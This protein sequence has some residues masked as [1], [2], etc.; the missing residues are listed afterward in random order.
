MSERFDVVHAAVA[1]A[2]QHALLSTRTISASNTWLLPSNSCSALA[3]AHAQHAAD[4]VGGVL[5]EGD[6]RPIGQRLQMVNAGMRMGSLILTK[7]RRGL[8]AP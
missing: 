6:L 4:V 7:R 1:E 8:A 2:H 5:A 3:G